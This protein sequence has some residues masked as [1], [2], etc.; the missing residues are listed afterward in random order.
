MGGNTNLI[1]RRPYNMCQYNR[2]LICLHKVMGIQVKCRM[3]T[4]AMGIMAT[5]IT[6]AAIN[7]LI[8]KTATMA[9]AVGVGVMVAI[10]GIMMMIKCLCRVFNF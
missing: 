3:A 9:K 5:A 7:P 1:T 8:I 10:D 6:R 2:V 4:M